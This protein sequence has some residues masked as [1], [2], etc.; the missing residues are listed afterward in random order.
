MP[1]GRRVARIISSPAFQLSRHRAA[2][3]VLSRRKRG[4][5]R[6][7]P[8]LAAPTSRPCLAT[9]TPLRDARNTS[10]APRYMRSETPPAKRGVA[11]EVTR[12]TRARD[13]DAMRRRQIRAWACALRGV[14]RPCRVDTTRVVVCRPF[15][16]FGRAAN[17][18]ASTPGQGGRGASQTR[19]SKKERHER[20]AE[21]P[22]EQSAP[23]Q[24]SP[25]Y[26]HF[27]K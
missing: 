6:G 4:T 23:R 18:I 12:S 8:H 19:F 9:E 2:R 24:T 16:P 21:R 26:G 17:E 15:H 27:Q 5:Y 22:N 3:D 13:F 1:I 20:G 11:L 14:D 10:S 25:P 7:V